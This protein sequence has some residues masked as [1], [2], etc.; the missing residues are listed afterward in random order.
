M[1]S[2]VL[3]LA[4]FENRKAIHQYL[5]EELGFPEYYG[6][7]LDALHDVLTTE[8][9]EPVHV[10]FD[11]TDLEDEDL[12]RYGERMLKVFRDAEE[13]CPEIL[14]TEYGHEEPAE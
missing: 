11:F 8:I 6:M 10:C 7:N 4:S 12:R 2:I 5:S 1:K 13:E 9:R 3:S 14:V